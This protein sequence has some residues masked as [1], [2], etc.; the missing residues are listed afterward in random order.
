MVYVLFQSSD[1]P[2]DKLHHTIPLPEGPASLFEEDSENDLE[3]GTNEMS[4]KTNISWYKTGI[5]LYSLILSCYI[6]LNTSNT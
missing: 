6:A 5:Y 3:S 1:N 4:G 2:W